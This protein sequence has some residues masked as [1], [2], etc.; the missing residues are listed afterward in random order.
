MII[1][2]IKWLSKSAE[3]AEVEISD[4]DFIC[5]AFSQPCNVVVGEHLTQPLHIFSIKNAVISD[6]SAVGIWNLSDT[7][8]ERKVV[9]KVID[10]TNQ[11][12]AVGDS[13]SEVPQH[14]YFFSNSLNWIG[15]IS[16]E[17][18]IDFGEV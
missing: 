14:T 17:G 9:A 8:I 18:Y 13:F 6:Q 1:K 2:S 3:E 15:C 10:I 16:A 7:K 12:V 4:G 5:I 11:V